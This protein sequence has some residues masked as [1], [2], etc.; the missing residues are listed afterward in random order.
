MEIELINDTLLE[1]LHWKAGEKASKSEILDLASE[2]LKI[3]ALEPGAEIPIKRQTDSSEYIVCLKGSISVIFLDELPNMDAGGPVHECPDG[4]N[5]F[6]TYRVKISPS[7]GTYG[8]K[9]PMGC[10]YTLEVND[11]CDI[12]EINI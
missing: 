9:I 2:S 5:F 3:C 10:W 7:E 1:V 12:I 6:E 8:V 11:K 4:R